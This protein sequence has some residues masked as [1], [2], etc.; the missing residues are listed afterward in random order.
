M[1]EP[2]TGLS[3]EGSGQGL[4]FRVARGP[5]WLSVRGGG[6]SFIVQWSSQCAGLW[7]AVLNA[8]HITRELNRT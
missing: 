2:M 8:A 1:A 5:G 4:S 6:K 3:L 7:L